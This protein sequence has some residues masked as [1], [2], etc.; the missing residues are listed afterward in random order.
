MTLEKTTRKVFF[1]SFKT[2]GFKAASGPQAA[3]HRF[4]NQ[5]RTESYEI[6][7]VTEGEALPGANSAVRRLFGARIKVC[8]GLGESGWQ[9]RG[10]FHVRNVKRSWYF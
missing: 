10:I 8:L 7:A 5:T 4:V 1:S 3:A 9:V 2:T 6:P